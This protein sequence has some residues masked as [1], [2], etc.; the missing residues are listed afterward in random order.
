MKKRVFFLTP[1]ILIAFALAFSPAIANADH[2]IKGK[3]HTDAFNMMGRS[4]PEKDE[5]TTTW[6]GKDKMRQDV[7]EVT[8]LIRLD[9]N[10]MYMINHSE[11]SYSEM[12]LP[13]DLEKMLPPEAKQMM[14]AMDISS[15]ITD[16]GETQTINNWKCKKYLVEI[17][18]SMMGMGMPIKMDMWTSK[19]LGVNLNEFKELYTKTL[20]A[21]PMFKDIIQ[22]FEKID[23]YPVVTEFSM[24]MMGAQQKYRE[25]VISVEKTGVP[26]GTYDLAEGYTKTT[27]NPFEQRR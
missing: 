10:K 8:T 15:S 6:L 19:D 21:N 3:K 17:S 20:A 16:T 2:I 7:G 13:F 4:E 5:D 26:A 27:Y 22:D 1:I 24:D 14:D 18:V 12:D 25:E 11:K 23:G 9:K